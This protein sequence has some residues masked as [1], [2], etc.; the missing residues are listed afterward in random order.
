MLE[1][2]RKKREEARK[3]NKGFTLMELLVV[4]AILGFLLAML[5]PR[6]MNYTDKTMG[7]AAAADAKNIMTIATSRMMELSAVPTVAQLEEAIGTDLTNRD[8]VV[9]L[10]DR[11]YTYTYTKGNVAIVTTIDIDNY[12][13]AFDVIATTA[14]ADTAKLER[15]AR[16]IGSGNSVK[17][18]GTDFTNFNE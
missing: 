16:G 7:V 3:N 13:T 15:V 17:V 11:T 2:L 6:Y 1:I 8:K 5:A 18:A 10:V 12:T 14:G 4:V 9:T